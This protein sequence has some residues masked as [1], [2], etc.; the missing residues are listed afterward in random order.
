METGCCLLPSASDISFITSFSLPFCLDLHSI[1]IRSRNPC[2]I[3]TYFFNVLFNTPVHYGN[4][5]FMCLFLFFLPSIGLDI[6]GGA[7]WWDWAFPNPA[8]LSGGELAA[9][10][11]AFS[12]LILIFLGSSLICIYNTMKS[13]RRDWTCQESGLQRNMKNQCLLETFSVRTVLLFMFQTVL[14][15]RLMSNIWDD[16]RVESA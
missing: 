9:Y 5:L 10:A 13:P 3:N 16:D 7:E 14:C 12:F 11:T 15:S 2:L 1:W 4:I 8:K 6:M